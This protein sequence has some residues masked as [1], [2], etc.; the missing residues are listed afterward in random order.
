MKFRIGDKVCYEG[1]P[2]KIIGGKLD[3]NFFVLIGLDRTIETVHFKFLKG[4][5]NENSN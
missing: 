1:K 2:Y 4:L 5:K 3:P